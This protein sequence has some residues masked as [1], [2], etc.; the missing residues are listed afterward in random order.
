LVSEWNS[1]LTDVR[2]NAIQFVKRIVLHHDLA[3]AFGG[4]LDHHLR[5][6]FFGQI[7]LEIL[8]VRIRCLLALD[9]A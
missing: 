1:V 4:V 8:D 6:E 5:A 7:V 2:Q 3:L 9:R